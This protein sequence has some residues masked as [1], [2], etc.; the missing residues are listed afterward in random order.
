MFYFFGYV[1]HVQDLCE[2]RERSIS[3]FDLVS[4]TFLCYFFVLGGERYKI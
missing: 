1:L 4:L 2:L 3:L